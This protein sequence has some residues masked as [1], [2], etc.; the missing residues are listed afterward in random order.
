MGHT[1][2]KDGVKPDPAKTKAICEFKPPTNVTELRQFLGM[3]NYLGRFL[4]NM[5]QATQPLNE[6]LQYDHVW[7]WDSTQQEAFIKVKNLI[8]STPVLAV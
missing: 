1:I 5:S 2:G 4:P 7:I 3:V 6:L 8:T